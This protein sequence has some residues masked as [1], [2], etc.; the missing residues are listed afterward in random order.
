MTRHLPEPILVESAQDW[1]SKWTNRLAASTRAS[2]DEFVRFADMALG[3]LVRVRP[4]H[5][6]TTNMEE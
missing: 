4:T 2:V 6:V 3:L 1:R 5:V